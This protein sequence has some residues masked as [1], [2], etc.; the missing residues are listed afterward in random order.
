MRIE[1]KNLQD[2]LTKAAKE[3]HCS[4]LDLEY[5]LI[6]R[7]S[8]GFL[9][10]FKK[11]AIIEVKSS[12]K[13]EKNS[14]KKKAY[15]IERSEEPKEFKEKQRQ[16][17]ANQA[18]NSAINSAHKSDF[19]PPPQAKNQ[20]PKPTPKAPLKSPT[21]RV[22]D[23]AIFESFHKESEDKASPQKA[24]EEIRVDLLHLL[25]ASNFEI[26]LTELSLQ[27]ESV[28]IKL[29]GDDAALLIGKE[30]YRYKALSY[31]LHNWINTKYN[32]LVRLEI[33]EFLKNQE[34]GMDFY[35]KG[36]IER[37][38][39][40]GKAQTKYLDG[41]L[42]KIALEKLRKAFPNKYVGIRQNGEQK[43]VIV[44]DFFKKDE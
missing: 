42:V 3:L 18:T 36:I 38:E 28:Y 43:Y 15:S 16:N 30:A 41:V 1:D 24:L 7:P 37:V 17:Y 6:Q 33:A 2:A 9:G 34:A 12:A 44:N 40:T 35:L 25:E 14:F 29:E 32:F 20:S 31:L 11:N 4:V 10:L 27:G 22:K 21:Y 39:A 13:P 5:E 8:S 19:T 23:E 26:K